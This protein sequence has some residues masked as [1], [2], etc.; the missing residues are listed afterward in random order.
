MIITLIGADFSKSNI[1][2]LSSWTVLCEL[3]AGATYTGP[4]SVEKNATFSATVTLNEGYEI[5]S[6]GITIT[7]G[8]TALD[9]S[10]YSIVD[11]VIT[12][13]VESVT[14]S[15]V[16]KVP[17]LNTNTGEEDVIPNYIFTIT[18]DPISATVTLSATG[19]S[20]V[21]GTGNQSIT[22]ADGT[23]VNWSVSADGYTEQTGTWT[24]NGSAETL[25]VTLSIVTPTNY[26]FTINPNPSTA[27]V[28]LTATGYTQNDNSI[29]VANGTSVSWKVSASGYTEQTGT[30][31][32][33]GSD[34][35]LPV[36]LNKENSGS[37]DGG[38]EDISA[39]IQD[40]KVV[41]KAGEL[42]NNA[43]FFAVVNYPVKEATYYLIPYARNGYC[44]KSD[45]TLVGGMLAGGGK[46]AAV[47]RAPMGAATITVCLK[48]ADIS[49]ADVT[50]TETT[51][52]ATT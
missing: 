22:V 7:M 4:S 5:S 32:A 12:F 48:H 51:A 44:L 14:G 35:T 52:P 46:E 15:I 43:Q 3:G 26:T 31:T 17:T 41:M 27:T 38:A 19:Y 21:S 36:T 42:S 11:N 29:T 25:P 33:N 49:P 45:G 37:G 20:T 28:T 47:L 16:I 34:E 40:G 10:Y 18:P 6:A 8:G 24:A 23:E 30:W 39:Y 9:K 1:G 13:T 50:I 2:T